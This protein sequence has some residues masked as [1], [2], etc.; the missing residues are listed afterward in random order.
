MRC[1]FSSAECIFSGTLPQSRQTATGGLRKSEGHRAWYVAF[2][3]QS[4]EP[5]REN[6]RVA[7]K[8]THV[9]HPGTERRRG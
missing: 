7:C 5:N 9:R 2:E 1:L 3:L 4:Q 8:V 6:T